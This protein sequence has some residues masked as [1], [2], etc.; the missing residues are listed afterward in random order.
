MK[1][2]TLI[3]CRATDLP[4]K[5]NPARA[6][7]AEEGKLA[8]PCHRW[9][10]RIWSRETGS[11]VPSRVS[12]LILH[13]QVEPGAYSRDSSRFSAS[14]G[15]AFTKSRSW[16]AEQGFFF[17]L[18]PFAA[19]KIWSRKTIGSAVPSRASLLILHTQAEP[20]AYSQDSSHFPRRRHSPFI[21]SPSVGSLPSFIRAHQLRAD[22][23]HCRESADP[24][25]VPG[26]VCIVLKAV[27]VTCAAYSII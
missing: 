24:G 9:H 27:P 20:G 4:G 1:R 5:V 18:S 23:V 3:A 19:L 6:G 15:L 16:S 26:M 25:P 8:F 11:D 10:L 14:T 7:P 12:L 21:P 17:P 2:C 22:G 13:T